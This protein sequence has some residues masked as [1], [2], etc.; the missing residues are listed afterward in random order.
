MIVNL[1]YLILS[2]SYGIIL[3]GKMEEIKRAKKRGKDEWVN[4]NILELTQRVAQRAGRIEMLK[5]EIRQLQAL[6][7]RRS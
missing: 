5:S 3:E 7:E 6:I 4:M 2:V 1:I